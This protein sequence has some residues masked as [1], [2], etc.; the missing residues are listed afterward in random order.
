MRWRCELCLW[1]VWMRRDAGQVV[2][3]VSGYMYLRWRHLQHHPFCHLLLSKENPAVCAQPG[4]GH[5]AGGKAEIQTCTTF[6]V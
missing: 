2:P 5:G 6:S 3:S 1:S 4:D